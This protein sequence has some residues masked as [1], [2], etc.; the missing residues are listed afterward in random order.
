[1]Q[2]N[3]PESASLVSTTSG[4]VETV[5]LVVGAV[6]RKP[7]EKDLDMHQIAVDPARQGTGV[8]SWLLQRIDEVV[9]A[10]RFGG[11]PAR[12]QDHRRPTRDR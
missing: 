8:G 3:L 1:M 10:R 9:Q 5:H 6:R 12:R 2:I 7:Q 11:S 4:G